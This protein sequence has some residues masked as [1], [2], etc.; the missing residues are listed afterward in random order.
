MFDFDGTITAKGVYEP[1]REMVESLVSLAEKMPIAFCTGRQLE[2]FLKHGYD[3][4][5]ADLSGER[6]ERFLENLFLMAE[7]GALGYFYNTEIGEFEEFYRV[8]WPDEFVGRDRFMK[9]IDVAVSE[10]GSVYFDAHRVV[11]VL[12]TNQHYIPIEKRDI[13]KVYQLSEKLYNV[14]VE[15]LSEMDPN[16]EKYLHVGNSGIGVV[17]SPANGDK[18]MGIQKFAEFLNKRRGFDIDAQA[19]DIM[20]VGDRPQKS[21]N[22]HYF[23]RGEFGTAYT[24]GSLVNGAKYPNPVLDEQG[25]RLL[26][27]IGTRYLISSTCVIKYESV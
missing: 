26:H 17:I 13:E 9:D 15:L 10:Y 23:L 22:D 1:S 27:D 21:G 11:V 6:L 4:L 12:R 19:R 24:V 3:S 18:D 14:A 20:V 2:S 16:F 7:N 25:N 8:P 5:V